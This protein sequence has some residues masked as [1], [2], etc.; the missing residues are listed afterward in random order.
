MTGGVWQPEKS[1]LHKLNKMFGD[2]ID[3]F[4]S[5]TPCYCNFLPVFYK[6]LQPYSFSSWKGILY[7]FRVEVPKLFWSHPWFLITLEK[8]KKL[9][10]LSYID[11]MFNHAPSKVPHTHPLVAFRESPG[12]HTLHFGNFFL[13]M[14]GG[15]ELKIVFLNPQGQYFF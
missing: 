3:H 9:N 1:L 5:Q 14:W 8:K 15:G 4:S 6:H 13:A 11:G 12:V 7:C 10:L 2:L